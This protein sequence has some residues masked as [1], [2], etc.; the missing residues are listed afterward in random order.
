VP[1]VVTRE[2]NGIVDDLHIYNIYNT[3]EV[4]VRHVLSLG[5]AR[6]PP[7]ISP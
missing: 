6:N 3:A 7:F 2:F 5:E 1:P 4:A